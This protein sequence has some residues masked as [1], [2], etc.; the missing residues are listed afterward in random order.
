LAEY[1]IKNNIK[2]SDFE[3]NKEK[4]IELYSEV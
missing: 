4:L 1:I 2:S 3:G